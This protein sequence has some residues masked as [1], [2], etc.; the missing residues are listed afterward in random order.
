LGIGITS[1]WATTEEGARLAIATGST[2][3]LLSRSDEEVDF[4]RHR[5][6]RFMRSSNEIVVKT[7]IQLLVRTLQSQLLLSDTDIVEVFSTDICSCRGVTLGNL[8][9][10]AFCFLDAFLKLPFFSSIEMTQVG[11]SAAISLPL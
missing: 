8:S 6:T 1:A 4:Q 2:S 7:T 11:W 9:I 10:E 5:R 3:S